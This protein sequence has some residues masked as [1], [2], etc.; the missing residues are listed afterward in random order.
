MIFPPDVNSKEFREIFHG[1]KKIE[2][3]TD[4]EKA[5]LNIILAALDCYNALKELMDT[6]LGELHK[7]ASWRKARAAIAKAEGK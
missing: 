6:P 3:I 7:V 1:T 5:E 4:A 2:N